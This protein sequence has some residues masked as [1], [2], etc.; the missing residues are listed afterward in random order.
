MSRA[1]A[2]RRCVW[3]RGSSRVRRSTCG[4]R[5]S[6][7][8]P[9]CSSAKC[10]WITRRRSRS[11]RTPTNTSRR[12][13][14]AKAQRSFELN[15]TDPDF[16]FPQV[17]RT[18]LAVDHRLPGGVTGTVE[19]LYNKDVNGTYYIN[20]NLPAAQTTFSG[21]DARPRW[22]AN[23]INNTA[24]N[25]ITSAFVLKNQDIG[26]SWNLSG[27][28]SKT[29]WHG[30]SLRGAYSYGEARNTI[31]PGS[32]ASS[33]FANN[34]IVNDPNNPGL[35]FSGYSQGHRVFVQGSYSRQYFNFGST[36]ISMFWEA[37]PSFQNFASNVSY[38]FNGDMNGDGFAGNDLIYIPR[39]T[40]EM[41][42]A[43]FTH[44][45]GRVFTAAEQAAA[46]EAYIQQDPYLSKHRGE[47]AERGGMFL[48]M[49]NRMDF[50]LMQDVFRNIGGKRNSGQFRLDITNFG[51]LLELGLGRHPAYGRARDRGQRHS[52]S[53]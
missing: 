47:Y 31:D 2:A 44:T 27:S 39:D 45:N 52:D 51:N 46:F 32:T 53:D 10:S 40:G 16:K 21:V 48:P 3:A 23:R 13:S 8:T 29:L 35:G 9:A 17:W 42:F 4:S 28:L 5:I 30:L 20:A 24:P 33:T 6:S 36:T 25:V 49:F 34:Q 38:V 26:K 41:N 7:G 18:N 15:V 11:A 37:K 1:T 12:T 19:F 14:R 22:T 43:T 50:S